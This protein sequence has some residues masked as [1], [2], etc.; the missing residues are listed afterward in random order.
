MTVWDDLVG[1]DS[2][3]A[4]LQAATASAQE[5]LDG[6]P[7]PAMTHAWLFTG[8]PGSGRSNAARAFAAALQC[9]T[10]GCGACQACRT[11]LSG[12]HPDVS[13]VS[14]DGLSIDVA[15]VREQVRLAAMRPAQ[16]RWQ[17]VVVEDADRL[18][19]KAA[20]ALLKSLEEPP[21]RTVWMLCAPTAEDVIVTIRSRSRQVVLR[22]PPVAAVA[23]MLTAREQVAPELAL[24]AARASQGHVGRARALATKE[25]VRERR[26]A[27]LAIP[28]SLTSLGA[29]LDAAATITQTAQAQ[30]DEVA[31]RLEDSE[32]DALKM[33]FGVED[34]GRRPAGYAG[35][36]A[37][38]EK[39]QKRRRTRI[40]R[41]SI[42]GVLIDLLSFYRDVLASQTAPGAELVNADVADS[43]RSLA[44]KGTP[45]QTLA[46]IEAILACRE[47]LEANAAPQLA[48][49]NLLL[50][51]RV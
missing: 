12:A 45:E 22:T 50:A 17:V 37:A 30:A 41:D 6:G 19:E 40:A 34:R 49:E 36:L 24:Q 48:L 3:V 11:A 25:P 7:G 32:R 4:M 46:R 10:G 38:L 39:D 29:C 28:G 31:E 27:V 1:Q 9:E 13:L 26:R 2:V 15:E 42:D 35:R 5:R 18:T 16:G 8:P 47:A 33:E 43:V 51:L 21:P 44:G 23:A 14:T 20:D